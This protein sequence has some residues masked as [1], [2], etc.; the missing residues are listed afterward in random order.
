MSFFSD[1]LKELDAD[2]KGTEA[3]ENTGSSLP[4]GKY[5]AAIEKAQLL[6]TKTD[7][8]PYLG[9]YLTVL[10]GLQKGGHAFVNHFLEKDRLPYLKK[11][12][13]T[14]GFELGA[15][16]EL[17]NELPHMLGLVVDI[18]VKTSESKKDGKSYTNTYINR[19]AGSTTQNMAAGA[20]NSRVPF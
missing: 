20:E 14:L 5:Q 3:A 8:R 2:W 17:E 10:D 16:S 18:T 15:L 1:H 6:T 12:L 4:D 7:D 11:D 13:Q 19:L 9:L